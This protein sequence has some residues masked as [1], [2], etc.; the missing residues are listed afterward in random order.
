ML[1]LG[2]FT[3]IMGGLIWLHKGENGN[4]FYIS[5]VCGQGTLQCGHATISTMCVQ[6]VCNWQANGRAWG[7]FC[8]MWSRE[9]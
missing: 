7:H 6:F 4:D 2:S 5:V 3:C 9:S 1:V 8:G